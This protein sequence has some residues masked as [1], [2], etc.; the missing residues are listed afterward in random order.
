MTLVWLHQVGY[1]GQAKRPEQQMTV[2]ATDERSGNRLSL[3]ERF[4]T[5][6]DWRTG[7]SSG[8]PP[9]FKPANQN[10]TNTTYGIPAAATTCDTVATAAW[11]PSRSA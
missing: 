4:E 3:H 7:C 10:C 11:A 1:R 5:F 6:F 8:S 9:N 2:L